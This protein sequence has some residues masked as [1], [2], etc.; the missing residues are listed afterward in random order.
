MFFRLGVRKP[1]AYAAHVFMGVPGRSR[2]TVYLSKIFQAFLPSK[3]HPSVGGVT[4]RLIDKS[5]CVHVVLAPAQPVPGPGR[6]TDVAGHPSRAQE[7][8][9]TVTLGQV[10]LDGSAVGMVLPMAPSGHRPSG[11]SRHRPSPPRRAWRRVPRG[12][13][14]IG[15]GGTNPPARNMEVALATRRRVR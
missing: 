1:S 8:P 3:T 4:S 10:G 13:A 9:R 11:P 12:T 15:H 7:K 5:T 2:N 14:S 6:G